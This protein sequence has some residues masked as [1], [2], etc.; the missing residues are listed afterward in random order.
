MSD[1]LRP[2]SFVHG[3][4]Q[5]RVLEWIAISFSRGSS[6]P[7]NQTRVSRIAGRRFTVWATREAPTYHCIETLMKEMPGFLSPQERLASPVNSSGINKEQNSWQ[8]QSSTQEASCSVLPDSTCSVFSFSFSGCAGSWL[9]PGLSACRESRLLSSCAGFSLPW[10]PLWSLVL[11]CTDFSS[12]CFGALKH[13]LSSC[14]A[15]T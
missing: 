8:I 7:R 2:G 11:W 9:L 5:A 4:F 13:R 15:R 12:C 10:L 6:R 1:S 3:I 14:G